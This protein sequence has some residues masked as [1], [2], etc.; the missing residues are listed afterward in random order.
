MT[1][2]NSPLDRAARALTRTLR[3]HG[4]ELHPDDVRGF[5]I[6]AITAIREPSES[7]LEAG[8][9]ADRG[10]MPWADQYRAMITVALA[11]R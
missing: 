2:G 4:V 10:M 1:T 7:M 5:A 9:I 3:H 6:D 8:N 11:D